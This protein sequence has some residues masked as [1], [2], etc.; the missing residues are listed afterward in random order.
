MIREPIHVGE[1]VTFLAA[2]NHTGM[3]SME[4]GIK[5]V[6]EDFGPREVDMSTAASSPWSRSTT[7]CGQ[8]PWLR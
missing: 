5:V 1:L 3:S 7:T 6:A 8:W 2:V 4:I